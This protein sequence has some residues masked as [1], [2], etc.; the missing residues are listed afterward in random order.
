MEYQIGDKVR[1]RED[2]VPFYAY[3]G[4]SV[5]PE[6]LSASGKVITIRGCRGWGDYEMSNGYF[7]S[8]EM[9]DQNYKPESEN[10]MKTSEF[11]AEL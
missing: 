4:I 6:M 2:L 5:F 1:I 3:G 7:Y 9:F 8:P 11:R 10:Y